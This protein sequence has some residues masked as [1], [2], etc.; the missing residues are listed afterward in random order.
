MLKNK[1]LRE[2]QNSPQV[3]NFAASSILATAS[4]I[5]ATASFKFLRKFYISPQ[6]S[7]FSASFKFHRKFQNSPQVLI[8]CTWLPGRSYAS[9]E[10][11]AWNCNYIH[12]ILWGTI[13]HPC[14]NFND[15]LDKPPLQLGHGWVI[16]SNG[17]PLDA[18]TYP[19]SVLQGHR[20]N[21]SYSLLVKEGPNIELGAKFK[22]RGE[23]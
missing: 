15:G 23:F 11:R 10:S 22:T 21:L 18:I 2:F 9:I 20:T 4:S 17:K 14:P 6:V 7:K 12:I 8:C 1:F 13:T 5:L 3:L 16:A 19:F